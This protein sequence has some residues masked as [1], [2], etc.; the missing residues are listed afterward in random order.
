MQV[1][2]TTRHGS[3]RDEAREHINQ[4]SEK[5]LTF[6]ERVTEIDVTVDFAGDRVKA[7][8]LVD[9]EHRHN[10]VAN[11]IGDEVIPTFDSAFHK[12]EQQI[13]KYKEKLQDHRRD[14]PLSELSKTESLDDS[15]DELPETD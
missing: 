2:I 6:F 12:M 15:D 14:V 10:F 3:I 5:L 9:T 8:I 11:D 13:K 4:K 1:A 7:E